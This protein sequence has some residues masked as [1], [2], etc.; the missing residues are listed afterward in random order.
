VSKTGTLIASGVIILVLLV[1]MV[2]YTVPFDRTAVL[3]RFG[4]AVAAQNENGDGAGLYWKWPWPIHSVRFYDRRIHLLER[5]LE[6]LLTR[7]GKTVAVSFYVAWRIDDPLA[8]HRSLQTEA[9]AVRTL[10]DLLSSAAGQ[11][12]E[13]DLAQ[14]TQRDPAKLRLGVLEEN[15]RSAIAEDI[16]GRQYGIRVDTVGVRRL[17]LPADVATKVFEQMREN[18][19]RLADKARDQGKS[20]AEVILSEAENDA[21]TIMSFAN[22]RAQAIRAEGDRAA[23]KHY[24]KFKDDEGFAIFLDKLETLKGSLK[25]NAFFLLDMQTTPF[26]LFKEMEPAGPKPE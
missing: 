20:D 22:R 2:S 26:D 25:K 21:R 6:E 1:Y 17:L 13:F 12:A 3:E 8:F 16:A 23:A 14:L 9:Q 4:K 7:D 15:I 10:G 24:A 5:R 11:L 18:R 19:K